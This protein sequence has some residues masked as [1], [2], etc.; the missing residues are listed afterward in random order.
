MST[1]TEKRTYAKAL[2]DALDFQELFAGCADR[3]EIAGSIRRRKTEVADVEH[4]VIPKRGMRPVPG[5]MFGQMDEFSLLWLR[6][7][8]LL[9]D[10]TIAKHVYP[11]THADGSASTRTMWGEKYRGCEFRGFN[12]EIFTATEDSWGAILAIRTGPA[13]FSQRLVTALHP[14]GLQCDGGRVKYKRDGSTYAVPTEEK[15][16]EACGVEWIEPEARR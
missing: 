5:S 10:G 8:E 16:F 15:F 2:H 4:V 6:C 14:R 9:A 3:W 1:A 12:H 11:V 13:E 7:D